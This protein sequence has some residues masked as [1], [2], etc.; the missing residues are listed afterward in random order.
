M[1]DIIG[2]RRRSIHLYL[3]VIK[4]K[5]RKSALKVFNKSTIGFGFIFYIFR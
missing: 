3:E 2:K 1:Q 4:M 5:P